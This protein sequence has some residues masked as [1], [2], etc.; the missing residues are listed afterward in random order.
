LPLAK[1]FADRV[2]SLSPA[3]AFSPQS[4]ALLEK[5]PWPGNIRELENAIVRAAAMCDGTIRP[6]DLPERLR[7]YRETVDLRDRQTETAQAE[8]I[9]EWPP[10]AEIEGRYVARVL[11][12]TGG[13]KQAAARLL[14]VD[15]K[16]L[17]RMIKRHKINSSTVAR[18]PSRVA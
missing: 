14:G 1:S 8:S 17:D 5:Y 2:Y 9:E 11:A 6:Q 16:T 15:R 7:G 13:N 12:H 4:L 3:V 10:L 18:F